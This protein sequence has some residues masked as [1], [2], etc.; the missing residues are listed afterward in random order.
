[1]LFNYWTIVI[2]IANTFQMFGSILYV[3]RSIVPLVYSEMFIGF[4]AMLIW[5]SLTRY[6]EHSKDFSFISRTI[7][8]GFPDVLRHLINVIPIYV[9]FAM[10]GMSIF[11]QSYRFRYPYMAI[12]TLFALSL[13]DEISNTFE[14]VT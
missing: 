7:A 13:G 12:F 10:L 3:F 2:L 8:H 9:G 4:G 11:W 6:I 5:V 1:M 14:D